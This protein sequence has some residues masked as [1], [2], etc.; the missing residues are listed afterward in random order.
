MDAWAP[1]IPP[2][3]AA[4]AEPLRLRQFLRAIRTNALTMWPEAAYRQPLIARPFLGRLNVLLNDPDDIHRVLV[5]NHANYRRSPASIRI[6]RPITGQGLLLSEGETWRLQR[7]TVAPALAPR[8]LPLLAR[9]VAATACDAL[10]AIAARADAPVDLLAA[11]QGLALGIAGRS[12]FSLEM[13]RHGPAMRDLLTEFAHRHARPHMFDMLLPPSVPTVRDIGRRRFQARWMRLMDGVMRERLDQAPPDAPRDLFDLLHAAR[14]PESGTG[15][16][17]T[18][19]RDQV[20]TLILAGHETTAV[21]LFWA[22]TLL[23]QAPRE[24]AMLAEE[25]SRIRIDPAAPMVDAASLPRT[26]AVINETLRLFPPAFTIVREAIGPDQFG[27]IKLPARSVVMIAPWVLHRHHAFW[28]DPAVFDPSRFM[29]DAASP[30]RFAFMPFGAG[31]RVCVGAQFALLEMT[32]VLALFMQRFHVALADTR[33][34]L[35]VAVVTTQPDHA[36]PFLL[37]AR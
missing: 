24:Q 3:P 5:D 11:M 14:D 15:F 2:V 30:P 9:H 27:T 4:P 6:L 23:A 1:F 22:L 34:V 31:P 7:R 17:P 33:P 29:P 26:R 13:N 16:T 28:R 32:L 36:P 19:L 10:D 37:R 25:A 12:M 18:Q 8:V 35:P 21:A 20:T